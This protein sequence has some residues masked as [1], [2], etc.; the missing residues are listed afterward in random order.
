MLG[1]TLSP[2][3]RRLLHIKTNIINENEVEYPGEQI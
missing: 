2:D 3:A 1:F